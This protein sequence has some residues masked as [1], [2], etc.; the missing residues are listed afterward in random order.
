MLVIRRSRRENESQEETLREDDN[1]DDVLYVE[2]DEDN[3]KEKESSI[4]KSVTMDTK[5]YSDRDDRSFTSPFAAS[6]AEWDTATDT[7][8]NTGRG[9]SAS[10]DESANAD[11]TP[12]TDSAGSASS[13]TSN[14]G[15][16]SYSYRRSRKQNDM[17]D[18]NQDNSQNV[19]ENKPLSDDT[20]NLDGQFS[21]MR[22]EFKTEEVVGTD[23]DDAGRIRRTKRKRS[24]VKSVE[25][26]GEPGVVST[27][28]MAKWAFSIPLY[29]MKEIVVPTVQ[30]GTVVWYDFKVWLSCMIGGR[31]E[32]D[33]FVDVIEEVDE[34]SEVNS[35]SGRTETEQFGMDEELSDEEKQLLELQRNAGKAMKQVE[36][37]FRV[38]QGG[39][40]KM[41]NDFK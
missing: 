5:S 2:S 17:E 31:A 28:S 18:S 20:T 11:E 24:V 15:V 35:F 36:G 4:G 33:Y 34:D 1:T 26:S 29:M 10:K 13:K 14:S 16:Y 39:V 9:F 22:N 38:V 23:I 30:V 25:S 32:D 37:A 19:S 12:S 41:W 27:G 21:R 8:T 3:D 40:E 6:R 7:D